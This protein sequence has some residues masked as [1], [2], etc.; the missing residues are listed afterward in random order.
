MNWIGDF[1]GD[2]VCRIFGIIFENMG[3]IFFGYNIIIFKGVGIRVFE[4]V[5]KEVIEKV[6]I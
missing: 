6:C 3:R 1:G 5:D 2:Y 4:Y